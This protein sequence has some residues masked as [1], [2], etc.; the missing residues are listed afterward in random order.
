L[1]TGGAGF[2][3][4]HLIENLVE[5]RGTPS[6]NI[7]VPRSSEYDLLS[8]SKCKEVV[9]G[10]DIVIH[11]AAKVGGI[12]YNQ[13]YPADL[14]R[15]N[16]L[17]GVNMIEAARQASVKKFIQIGTVCAYPKFAKIPFKEEELWD[18][19]PEETNA[20]YG[21][22]KKA[23]LVMAQAYRA[24][25]GMN[26]IYLLPV[27]LYGPR[28]NFDPQSSHVI[29]ALIRRYIE[30]AASNITQVTLW[31]TGNASREFLYVK[32]AAEGILL[33][34]EKYDEPEPVNLGFGAEIRI[35]ELAAMIAKE[36]GFKG[37]TAWDP[38]RPDGQPRR[39]LDTGK[40][41]EKFGFRAITDLTSGLRET[42]RWYRDNVSSTVGSP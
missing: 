1:V 40:A 32:D 10:K 15:D 17:M 18:G 14:F 27:N 6:G 11:L 2:L 5:K 12:G 24:Q 35:K 25:Y 30:A 8:F 42:M 4:S 16:I 20:P 41:Y 31:G 36:A 7:F 21:I 9:E 26:I 38:S 13:K 28:D 39:C 19:Y 23:L 33:A 34:A 29:P 37:K 3:G 22:A